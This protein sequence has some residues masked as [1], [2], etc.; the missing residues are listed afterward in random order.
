MCFNMNAQEIISDSIE[1]DNRYREDQ[2]YLGVTYNLLGNNDLNISQ[3]GFSSGFHFGFIRDMPINK[4]RTMAIGAGVGYS[5]NA[6]NQNLGITETST[7]Y[8]YELLETDSFQKN[9]FSLHI[10]EFPLELRWRQSS[11]EIYK[12]WRIYTGV[13]FG[14][15]FA[16]SVKFKNEFGT[17]KL[18]NINDFSEFQYGLTLSV[19]YNIVNAH[20]YFGLNSIFEDAAQ[21]EGKTI[22]TN[23]IKIGLIIYVL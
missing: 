16:S 20:I 6:V 12:F 4:S 3:T 17:T 10:V 1:V 9:R 2:F 19:G 14:Y 5:A 18:K 11:P 13:K 22:D 21:L 7:T 15:V 23:L 8:T